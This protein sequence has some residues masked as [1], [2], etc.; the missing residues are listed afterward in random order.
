MILTN[1]LYVTFD[2]PYYCIIC[3]YNNYIMVYR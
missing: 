2:F 3:K 1:I